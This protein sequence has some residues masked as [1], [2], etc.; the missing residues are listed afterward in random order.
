MKY[1]EEYK[2]QNCIP[3]EYPTISIVH[4]HYLLIKSAYEDPCNY[5]FINLSQACVPLK[6][7]DYIY[8]FLTK[9]NDAHFNVAPHNQCFPR[10]NPVLEFI[11]KNVIHKSSNW[12]IL[13]RQLSLLVTNN[14]S[15][16]NYFKTIPSPEE[17]YYI[18]LIHDSYMDK[19]IITTP[20]LAAGATTFTN[21]DDMDYKYV[22]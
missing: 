9:D 21:W 15:Y 17:H 7:F 20:N 5:K 16:I 10:C 3:T 4:A 1:F 18:T 11:P 8:D 6:S 22:H 2:L 19:Q 13:N 12:F 14:D